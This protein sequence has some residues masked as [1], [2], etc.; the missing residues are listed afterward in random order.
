MSACLLAITHTE[1]KPLSALL[2][3]LQWIS[4]ALSL[5]Y[6]L[7]ITRV[8]QKGMG[9]EVIQGDEIALAIFGV[10]ILGA[11]ALRFHKRTDGAYSIPPNFGGSYAY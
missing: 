11:A 8:L 2:Q 9:I 3:V 1:F 6:Y 5:R 7:A 4:Y 10:M